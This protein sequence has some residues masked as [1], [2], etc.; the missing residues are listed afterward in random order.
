MSGTKSQ[1][2]IA[3]LGRWRLDFHRYRARATRYSSGGQNTPGPWW[4]LDVWRVGVF[5]L[6]HDRTL[7]GWSD[8]TNATPQPP[9]GEDA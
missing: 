6:G 5:T 8:P 7:F 4:C 3:Q 2:R 1:R 9:A